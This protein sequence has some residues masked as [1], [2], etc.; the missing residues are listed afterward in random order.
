MLTGKQRVFETDKSFSEDVASDMTAAFSLPLHDPK[1]VHAERVSGRKIVYFDHNVWIELRD[2]RNGNA[3]ACL[4]FCRAAVER[5][6]VVLPLAFPA[7]TEAIEIPDLSTRLA[8]ADLLD[9]LSSGVTFRSSQVLM[10]LEARLAYQWLFKDQQESMVPE[11]EVFTSLP[12][13]LGDASMDFPSGWSR[14]DAT[15][16]VRDVAADS[17]VR[18]VRFVAEQRDWRKD[19]ED[20][21]ERYVR[22]MERV[23]AELA[24]APRQQKQAVLARLLED[25]R[26]SLMK[27]HVI[28]ECSKQLISE[29]GLQG[30]GA[31][32]KQ[33]AARKGLGGSKRVKEIF[34][35]MPMMDQH[36][37]IFA[38]NAKET[39]R[40]PREQDF[41]DFDHGT[42]PPIYSDAFA[43]LDGRLA[44]LVREAGRGRAQVLC[45]LAEIT[46][47]LRRI[48][49]SDAG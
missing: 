43:T 49:G 19:H 34:K 32:F 35:R 9:S 47:W 25:E 14:E 28:P 2:A 7:V 29:V 42:A 11:D 16:M 13:Y 23:R 4:D 45:S 21:R 12:N 20:L 41:F 39:G 5:A 44:T 10:G 26:V 40:R 22:E 6:K 27:L 24:R 18:S 36:A 33:I 48:M 38:H 46:E 1:A 8:H 17:K 37:R 3:I 15:R 31:A 30:A